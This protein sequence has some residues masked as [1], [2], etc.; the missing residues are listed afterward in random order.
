MNQK[1][2]KSAQPNTYG[3]N[4]H[5]DQLHEAELEEV[6]GGIILGFRPPF[7]PKMPLKNPLEDFTGSD[8]VSLMRRKS[9]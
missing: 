2:I 6:S 4:E 8:V 1:E 7:I 5:D 9:R 3:I